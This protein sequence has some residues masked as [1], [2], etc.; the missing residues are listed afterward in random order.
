MDI[1]EFAMK[2]EID[3]K[4][5]YEEQA[6]KTKQKE[7]KEILKTLAEEEQRHFNFFKKMRDGET[8]NAADE[9]KTSTPTLARVK[10]I[11]IELGADKSKKSFGKDEQAVWT[12][13]LRIEEKAESFYRDK[14]K[15][16]KD[17]T[18]RRLLLLIAEE[19]QN[20]VHMISS[21]MTYLKFPDTFADSA[22]FKNFQS[23]EGH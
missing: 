5:Y 22:Q 13:A 11:F 21:V 9:I 20:H 17:E 23:L 15:E 4:H 14:A 18:L 3:G 19:E 10:N 12:E 7:L 1:F 16:E 2:M 8:A 6:A